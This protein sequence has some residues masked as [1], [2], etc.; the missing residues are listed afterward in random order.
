MRWEMQWSENGPCYAF[1]SQTTYLNH[2]CRCWYDILGRRSYIRGLHP[3]CSFHEE[4]NRADRHTFQTM[5]LRRRENFQCK[6]NYTD[7][8]S[9]HEFS[10]AG[11]QRKLVWRCCITSSHIGVR[12]S[13][14]IIP[15][16]SDASL[17]LLLRTR[18]ELRY[19]TR[20]NSRLLRLSHIWRGYHWYSRCPSDLISEDLW[21]DYM[22]LRLS[23]QVYQAT[24]THV[25]KKCLASM[26]TISLK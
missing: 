9:A 11:W 24:E 18:P 23:S 3:I 1:F 26:K 8:N 15:V 19:Q 20:R 25:S 6:L 7:T 5:Y 21:H 12:P 2:R 10:L 13:A 22:F 14:R 17:W 4:N 16:V